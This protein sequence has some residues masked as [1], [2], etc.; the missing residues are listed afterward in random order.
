[1][2]EEAKRGPGRPR[3][4]PKDLRR[5]V[6]LK[7]SMR[8]HEAAKAKAQEAGLNFSDYVRSRIL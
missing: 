3:K 8:E 2:K 7:L 5:H 4:A 6:T 1:M